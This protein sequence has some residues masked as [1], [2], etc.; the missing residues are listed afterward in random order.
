[1]L[2]DIASWYLKNYICNDKDTGKKF[3]IET[4]KLIFILGKSQ[5]HLR[6]IL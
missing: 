5:Y 6:V 2:G 3:G 1:M 4:I